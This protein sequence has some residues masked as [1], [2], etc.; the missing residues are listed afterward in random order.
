MIEAVGSAVTGLKK[1][2]RVVY[3]GMRAV[4]RESD[5]VVGEIGAIAEQIDHR[6]AGYRLKPPGGN[7]LRR[8]LARNAAGNAA[9]EHHNGCQPAEHRR[10]VQARVENGQTA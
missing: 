2:D 10:H 7:F 8:R 3:A 9:G 4:E 1:G 6:L 5:G